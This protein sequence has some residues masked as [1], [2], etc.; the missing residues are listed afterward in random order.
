MPAVQ[1]L[2][3]STVL[4]VDDDDSGSGY[5]TIQL[6]TEVTPP[7]RKRARIEKTTLT[8]TLATDDMGIEL[9]SDMETTLFWD[10]NETNNNIFETLFA[11]K[12]EVLWKIA[13]SSSVT[14]VFNG[15]IAELA[16]EAI[17]KDNHVMRKVTIHRTGAITYA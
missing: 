6:V 11:A 2:G 13:F 14:A 1:R 4:S 7:G 12:T 9:Q 16:P 17:K 15:I 8:D 10:P 5:T 3:L